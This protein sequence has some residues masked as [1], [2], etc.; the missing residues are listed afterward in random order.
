[1]VGLTHAL[2][3]LSDSL[4][5]RFV[6]ADPG[7][8]VPL[9][10]GQLG[11]VRK[12]QLAA[13]LALTPA[14]MLANVG[15]A[16]A[17]VVLESGIGTL[18]WPTIVW[19]FAVLAFALVGVA[20]ARRFSRARPRQTASRRGPG[21]I[22]LS[23]FLLAVLW[24]YPLIFFLRDGPP[25]E[26]A[27]I[28]ALTAGMVAGGALAL[29][30]VPL[31][32]LVYT[33]TLSATAMVCIMASL[34]GQAIP[35]TLI[36]SAFMGIVL[37]S[38][39]RHAVLFLSEFVQRLEAERQR[40]MVQLLLGSFQG[41]GGQCLWQGDA[42]LALTTDPVPLALMLGAGEGHTVP[43]DLISILAASGAR[44]YDADS[45]RQ[46]AELSRLK[47]G[48]LM[49][50]DM[51][52]TT[53]GGM[54]FKLVGKHARTT[55]AGVLGYHGYVKDITVETR[56]REDVYRLATRDTMTDLLNYPEFV[57]RAQSLKDLPSTALA[58]GEAGT[59]CHLF[60]FVDADNLKMVNDNFG[61][62]VGDLLIAE[63]A[64]RLR[65]AVADRGL[66]CRKGGDEFL[67]FLACGDPQ[68]AE[69]IA[70][71]VIAT[72]NRSFFCRDR[73]IPISC[74]V[75]ATISADA[76][77]TMQ[78]LEL[79]ADRA[80][81]FAKSRGKRQLKL[82]D[83][84]V[85]GDIRR[86]RVLARGLP[87]ALAGGDLSVAFQPILRLIDRRI[88]GCEARLRWRHPE[89]GDIPEDKIVAIAKAEGHGPA[90]SDFVL[91]SSCE[92]A[93]DWPDTTFV[94]VN[95]G[96]ADLGYPDLPARVTATLAAAGLAPQRL[97]LELTESE[98][99]QNGGAVMVNLEALRK[100]GVSIAVDDFGA[101]YSS[102]SYVDRYPSVVIKI[103]R[104]LIEHCDS[105]DSSRIILRAI[106]SLAQVNGHQVIADGIETE[107]ELTAVIAAE[108]GYGQGGVFFPPLSGNSITELFADQR[109]PLDALSA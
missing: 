109:T 60:L 54:V 43:R 92:A 36:I 11:F 102:F 64:G 14:M 105:R 16:F 23:S 37:Y 89:L 18:Q 24:C 95:I 8:R 2:G 50:F 57:L 106:R 22:V 45:A 41:A 63:I 87:A 53:A 58:P 20:D 29:Y 96:T 66:L 65:A 35:F 100:T 51:T 59:T 32:A 97:W 93:L 55:A 13:V 48:A 98:L 62:A 104:S 33:V 1:M 88:V 49:Q 31:A 17:L 25:L 61:H 7:R 26:L 81:Y 67:A 108:I 42:D 30:P 75:G 72:I 5:L 47:D 86:D 94:S 71:N 83:A 3:R 77:A 21:R 40:D 76:E 19:F 68:E 74:C 84:E 101:G 52:M 38:I 99:V 56:A 12:A 79:E 15:N 107:D 85:G 28:C 82:Y 39:R 27:F 4:T 44:P 34:I 46:F 70:Q 78:Q 80:L 91:R 69:E 10:A 90:L 103:N 73:N 6:G 9:G